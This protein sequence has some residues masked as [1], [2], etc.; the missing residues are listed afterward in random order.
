VIALPAPPQGRPWPKDGRD[1]L[2]RGGGGEAVRRGGG[3]ATSTTGGQ[4]AVPKGWSCWC[5]RGRAM[6][7]SCDRRLK[8]DTGERATWVNKILFISST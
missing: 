3:V 2:V 8:N 1:D 6:V 4:W 7:T 5:G